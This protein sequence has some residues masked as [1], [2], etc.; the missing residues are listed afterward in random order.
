M[1]AELTV[2]LPVKIHSA[3]GNGLIEF[4]VTFDQTSHKQDRCH[5]GRSR[6]KIQRHEYPCVVCDLYFFVRDEKTPWRNKS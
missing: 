4:G 1:D 6:I 5:T 3:N 2:L